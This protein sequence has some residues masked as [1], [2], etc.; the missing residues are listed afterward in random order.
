MVG[1]KGRFNFDYEK[2][3]TNF[4]SIPSLNLFLFVGQVRT[5]SV[6]SSEGRILTLFF[7][8]STLDLGINNPDSDFSTPVES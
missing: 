5:G 3:L 4:C 1:T 2:M 6:F 7:T 8:E